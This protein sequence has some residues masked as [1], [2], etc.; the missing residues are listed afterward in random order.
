MIETERLVLRR[1]KP[2]DLDPY[3]A[4]MADPE[5]A[6]WLSGPMTREQSAAGIAR[7]EGWFERDG[8]GIF[9]VERRSDEALIG[10]IGLGRLDDRYALTPVAGMVEIGWRLARSTWGAG[11]ASEGARAVLDDAFGRLALKSIVAFTAEANARSRAVMERLGF[12]RAAERDFDHPSLAEGHP[13]RRHVVYRLQR[14]RVGEDGET[15]AGV[16]RL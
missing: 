11:F 14:A 6:D 15:D 10:A 3:A 9:A 8:F 5:V 7:F 2:E 13:L 1:W 4:I 12:A 16:G